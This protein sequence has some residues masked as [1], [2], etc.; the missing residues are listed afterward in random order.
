[1]TGSSE[2][3]WMSGDFNEFSLYENID[4]SMKD[5]SNMKYVVRFIDLYL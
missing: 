4:I 5:E 1:M 3:R 2:E